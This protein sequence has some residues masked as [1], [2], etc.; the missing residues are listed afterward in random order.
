MS[1]EISLVLIVMCISLLI[2]YK[3]DKQL[4]VLLEGKLFKHNLNTKLAAPLYKS[5]CSWWSVLAFALGGSGI[6][7]SVI[8]HANKHQSFLIIVILTVFVLAIGVWSR[9]RAFRL[10]DRELNTSLE[11]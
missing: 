10:A 1:R 8:A 6:A 11:R 4:I 2:S 7:L 5:F 3:A 9:L